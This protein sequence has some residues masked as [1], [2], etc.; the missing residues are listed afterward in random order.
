MPFLWRAENREMGIWVMP[1]SAVLLHS[2]QTVWSDGEAWRGHRIGCT[3]E[4]RRLRTLTE[5]LVF[6]FCFFSVFNR[7]RLLYGE[8]DAAGSLDFVLLCLAFTMLESVGWN[9]LGGTNFWTSVS[10]CTLAPAAALYQRLRM[11]AQTAWHRYRAVW[12]PPKTHEN[13]SREPCR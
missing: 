9:Q 1:W 4:G 3:G 6:Y 5:L 13:L 8:G 11:L 10:I 2:W 7:V 12:P